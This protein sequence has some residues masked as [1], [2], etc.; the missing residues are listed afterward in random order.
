MEM[1]MSDEEE[2]FKTFGTHRRLGQSERGPYSD[3]V[4][5]RVRIS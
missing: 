4:V 2:L 3:M 5:G 1:L